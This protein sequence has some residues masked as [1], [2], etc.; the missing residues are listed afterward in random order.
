MP[1]SAARGRAAFVRAV[2][3]ALAARRRRGKAAFKQTDVIKA[4]K[5]ARAAGLDIARVEIDHTG[6]QSKITI[7]VGKEP[8]STGADDDVEK[9]LAKHAH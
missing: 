8:E 4:V 1:V 9:W 5:A 2:A 3:A 7:V 6:P